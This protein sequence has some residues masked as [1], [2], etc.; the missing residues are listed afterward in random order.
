M[1]KVRAHL[2]IDG[3]VQGVCFRLDARRAAIERN[4]TGWV[5]NLPDGR[6]EALFE[7]EESDVRSAIKWCEIG[8]PIARVTE[9][10][11][12]WEQYTGEFSSFEI[13]F[14]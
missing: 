6:V 12:E 9:V 5:K 1:K 4:L 11:V 13:T 14:A 10:A 7:G 8:P 2:R 3:R